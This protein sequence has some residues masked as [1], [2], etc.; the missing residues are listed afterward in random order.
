MPMSRVFGETYGGAPKE[1]RLLL[2][3]RRRV[4][5][6]RWR[7]I[8][9]CHCGVRSAFMVVVDLSGAFAYCLK[10]AQSLGLWPL[11]T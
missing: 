3:R 5:R 7:H 11:R 6:S 10:D 4:M 8:P 2:R 9:C 1:P